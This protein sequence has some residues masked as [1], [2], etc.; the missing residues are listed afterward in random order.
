MFVRDWKRVSERE[1]E[2]ERER[3]RLKRYVC[4]RLEERENE[5]K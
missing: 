4:K 3:E 1:S 2:R 5:S